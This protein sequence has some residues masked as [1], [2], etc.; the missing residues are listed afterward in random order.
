[1]PTYGNE[2]QGRYEAQ[3]WARGIWTTVWT[4]QA[5]IFHIAVVSDENNIHL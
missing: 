5:H 3:E 1:M 4:S 2:T